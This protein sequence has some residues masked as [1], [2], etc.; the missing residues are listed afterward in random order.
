MATPQRSWMM[1][2]VAQKDAS[3]IFVWKCSASNQ[4]FLFVTAR[5]SVSLLQPHG[6]LKEWYCGQISALS[7]WI[8]SLLLLWVS[9]QCTTFIRNFPIKFF[10]MQLYSEKLTSLL[11]RKVLQWACLYVC[12]SVRLSVRLHISK[13]TSPNFTKFSVH[14]L[15]PSL[16]P[17]HRT[18]EYVMYFRF[19]GWR[20][21]STQDTLIRQITTCLRLC[22]LGFV[23]RVQVNILF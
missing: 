11:L 7:L 8:S 2:A 14:I 4:P 22:R 13:T 9:I 18:M 21:I 16:G 3:S 10:P 1:F 12:L 17:P 15:W 6:K 20:H 5:G 19:C 23:L